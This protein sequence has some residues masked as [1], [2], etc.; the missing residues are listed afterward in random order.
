MITIYS[1]VGRREHM[2]FGNICVCVCG[3]HWA[4]A[5]GSLAKRHISDLR[6][7]VDRLYV[8]LSALLFFGGGL[9]G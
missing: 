1:I 7:I 5:K 3:N 4:A 8:V 9:F 6:A 2:R